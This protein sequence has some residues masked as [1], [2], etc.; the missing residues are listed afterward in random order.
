MNLSQIIKPSLLIDPHRCKANI[1]KMVEKAATNGFELRP[2][3]KT[4]QSHIIG[5]WFRDEGINKITVSSVGMA[6]F[7]AMNGW[8]DMT[9]AFPVNVRQMSEINELAQNVKLGLVVVDADSVDILGRELSDNV[10][11]WIKIDV[12]THRTGILPEHTDTIDEIVKR[13][14]LY[15]RLTFIGFLGHS[16]HSYQSKTAAQVERTHHNALDMMTKLVKR[17][18]SAYPDLI[19][20]LGDT[21]AA[22]MVSD[23][24]TVDE[25]RPGNF[26]FYDLQ[27]EEIGSCSLDEIAVAMVCPVVAVHP[28]RLQWIIYGGGIHFSKDFLTLQDGKKCF[29]RWVKQESKSWSTSETRN[30]PFLNSLSQEHGVIQCTEQTFNLC[31]PGDLSLWLPVHSCM[32]A[33]AMGEYY[34]IDGGKIDHYR[35]HLWS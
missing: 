30:G 27:Q 31:K 1:H 19:I 20:S 33:D 22:S 16:G 3:F 26:V 29:G 4:H 25:F 6:S 2:H 8:D 10:S 14:K 23:F 35:E 5:S 9:I 13:I 32:T 12:G 21:P 11:V 15:P 17:Y 7:F 34:S 18:K 28:E 24:G